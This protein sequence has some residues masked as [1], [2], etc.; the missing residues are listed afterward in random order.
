VFRKIL[1]P[2]DGS[3]LAEKAMPYAEALAQKFESELVLGWVVQLKVQTLPE[4][5]PFPLGMAAVYTTEAETQRGQH[6]LAEIQRGLGQRQLRCSTRVVEGYS[7]ADAIV[8]IA[9]QERVDLIVKTTYAR[10]GLSRWLHGNVA[11]AVLQRAPCPL[12]LVRVSDE[13]GAAD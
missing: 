4:H 3:K 12:F 11:A 13:D 8:A 6:Y 1:V 2:L 9:M 10:L 5:E 7:I